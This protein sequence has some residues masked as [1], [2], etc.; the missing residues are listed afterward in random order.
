MES[1]S[2]SGT[3]I[4][5]ATPTHRPDAIADAVRSEGL[6][7]MVVESVNAIPIP[8]S[9][10]APACLVANLADL[11]RACPEV[12]TVAGEA[13][14]WPG[15]TND[16]PPDLSRSPRPDESQTS[17]WALVMSLSRW[18]HLKDRTVAGACSLVRLGR[19][20]GELLRAVRRALEQDDLARAS[21]GRGELLRRLE[22]LN[23]RDIQVMRLI[24][25]EYPNKAIAA[26]LDISQRTVEGIRAKIFRVLEVA[27]GIG[28]ARVLTE[29][30]YFDDRG[31]A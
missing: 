31:D 22:K 17:R 6:D 9:H 5:A 11:L 28:L 4:V 20:P 21:P 27:T 3:V 30:R 24:Y 10:P 15:E 14:T 26:E 23:A 16:T 13:E 18:R 8:E 1:D 29:A 2:V 25:D 19:D 12:I 7:T